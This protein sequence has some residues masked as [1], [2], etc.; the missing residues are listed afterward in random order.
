[1]LIK[2]K[3][4][5]YLGEVMYSWP[6]LTSVVI[7]GDEGSS[8]FIPSSPLGGMMTFIPIVIPRK[9]QSHPNINV[10]SSYNITTMSDDDEDYN[11]VDDAD[12]R[13][14]K[15]QKYIKDQNDNHG[16]LQDVDEAEQ[17]VEYRG[18]LIDID[19]PYEDEE[20]EEKDDKAN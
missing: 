7:W 5:Y 10:V 9:S 4:K 17:T 6:N 16:N 13:S 18:N 2:L 3:F 11:S 8:Q 15:D 14:V 19:T 1:M 12:Q 20:E